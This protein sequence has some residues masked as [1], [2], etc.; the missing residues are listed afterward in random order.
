MAR[1]QLGRA[2]PQ[3]RV[4]R[5]R[6]LRPPAVLDVVDQLDQPVERRGRNALFGG[7][8][9]DD[10]DLRIDLGLALAHGEIAVDAGVGF[11]GLRGVVPR[12]TR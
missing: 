1:G 11:R 12:A 7:E 10:P 8:L 6:T 2:G 3:Q 9:A 4:E 5:F